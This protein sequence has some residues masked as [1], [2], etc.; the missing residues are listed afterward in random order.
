MCVNS[1]L[2]LKDFNISIILPLGGVTRIHF[3]DQTRRNSVQCFVTGIG[4]AQHQGLPEILET[5]EHNGWYQ[6]VKKKTANSPAARV[7]E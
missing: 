7:L 6:M 2:S 5:R 3:L 4:W 1:V